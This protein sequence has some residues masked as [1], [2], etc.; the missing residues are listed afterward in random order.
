MTNRLPM[1]TN[2]LIIE[3][4]D[5]SGKSTLFRNL[6]E[7]TGFK[8]NI[9]DRSALSMLCY[10]RQF[11]RD[12]NVERIR[13]DQEINNLNNRIIILLPGFDVIKKRYLQ[14]GDEIQDLASLERL[15]RIFKEEGEKI[16]HRPNVIF[17]DVEESV[18]DLTM[19][20]EEWIYAL[21]SC[22][23]EDLGDVVKDTLHGIN[24]DEAILQSRV[25]YEISPVD[26]QILENP[27]EG[28]YYSEILDKA[29]KIIEDEQAGKNEYN[30]PQGITSRRYYYNSSTC[31]SSIHFLPRNESLNTLV[32]FRSL[33]VD[34]NA[35]IDLKFIE[36]LVFRINQ[37][38]DFKCKNADVR[39]TFNNAHIRKNSEE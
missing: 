6:H 12:T 7:A 26:D 27:L 22:R 38:F 1:L 8:W 35:R 3:G 15:H 25:M 20:I 5:L 11:G 2:Q 36:Y 13:L 18:D 9:Q 37:K 30:T 21:E 17:L 34:K 32:T 33:D 10:A 23:L 28:E 29:C 31:I 19:C 24:E 4:P 14:R 16:R 39:I